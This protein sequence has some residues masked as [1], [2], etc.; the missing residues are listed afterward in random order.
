METIQDFFQSQFDFQTLHYLKMHEIASDILKD[1]FQ[2]RHYQLLKALHAAQLPVDRWEH[3][4]AAK[5]Y[6]KSCSKQKMHIYIL[7]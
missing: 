7:F 5:A 6:L 1:V 4:G 3:R 2:K